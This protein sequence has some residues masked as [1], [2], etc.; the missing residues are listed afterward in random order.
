MAAGPPF[1]PSRGPLGAVVPCTPSPAAASGG[2][3]GQYYCSRRAPLCP[4]SSARPARGGPGGC[5][6]TGRRAMVAAAASTGGLWARAFAGTGGSEAPSVEGLR[7]CGNGAGGTHGWQQGKG[8]RGPPGRWGR[9]GDEGSRWAG[10]LVQGARVVLL[11]PSP[12]GS[13]SRRSAGV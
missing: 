7:R 8:L 13:S 11:R 10:A 5:K 9:F 3:P 4:R 1:S 6:Q 2:G 12:A